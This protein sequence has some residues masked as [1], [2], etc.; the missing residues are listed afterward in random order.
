MTDYV[1]NVEGVKRDGQARDLDKRDNSS[2]NF[3]G[4]YARGSSLPTLTAK[5]IQSAVPASTGNYWGTPSN[6]FLDNQ[7]VGHVTGSR[8]FSDHSCFRCG[9]LGYIIRNY[10]QPHSFESK[11]QPSRA[12]VPIGNGNNGSTCPQIGRGGNHKGHGG[13][14]NGNGGRD[15]IQPA[16]E[17]ARVD[18]R[19]HIYAFPGKNKAE[20][21][22]AVIT[23]TILTCD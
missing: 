7:S 8:P 3:Q 11:Q 14:E 2:Q 15:N 16:R 21:A 18:D 5:P 12:I 20:A 19:A 13:R 23:C 4:S 1:K 6:H 9:K 17:V 22:D 10:S